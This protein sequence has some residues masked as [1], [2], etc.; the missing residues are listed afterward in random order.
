[1]EQAVYWT[2]YVIR[3]NGAPH[4]RSAVLDLAWYQYFLLDVIAVLALVVVCVFVAVYLISL[5]VIRRLFNTMPRKTTSVVKKN[6]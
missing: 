3:H 6:N 5:V 1:M 4:L 2:E